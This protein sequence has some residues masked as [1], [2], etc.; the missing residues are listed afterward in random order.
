MKPARVEISAPGSMP[1]HVVRAPFANAPDSKRAPKIE[2]QELDLKDELVVLEEGTKKRNR[3]F[4]KQ[5]D[6]I[7]ERGKKWEVKMKVEVEE[8]KEAHQQLLELFDKT[9][10]TAISVEK[11][12]LVEAIELFHTDKTPPQETRMTENEQGVE[13]F[14][15]E[16]IPAVVDRQ[17]GIVSRKLQKAHDT[18]DIE[19]QKVLKR[20]QKIVSRFRKHAERT[21]QAFEDERATRL[22][23]FMLLGEEISDTERHDDRQEEKSVRVVIDEIIKIRDLEKEETAI[24]EKEDNTLLDT[25]LYAQQRLQ[26]SVLKSFGAE[27][28]ISLS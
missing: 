1:T 25:M 10:S 4:Y 11:K 27:A 28:D 7:E 13:V 19:N 22:S 8:Q 15:G 5:L 14:V 26:E 21:A 3:E 20:E 9:L 12:S 6:E 18:F 24:R 16:T 23:K 17:S 2:K